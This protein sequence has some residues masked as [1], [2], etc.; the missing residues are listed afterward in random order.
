MAAPGVSENV[1]TFAFLAGPAAAYAPPVAAA[2]RTIPVIESRLR[3]ANDEMRAGRFGHALEEFDLALA[4][5]PRSGLARTGR[6][7]C[8]SQMGHGDAA[9]LEL[10]STLEGEEGAR[11]AL[12]L[13]RAAAK[14]GDIRLAVDLAC[15]AASASPRVARE[16]LD[17][18]RLAGVRDHPVFMTAL[19]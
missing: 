6:A 13:A 12:D 1:D 11:V 17:D 4:A 5:D 14:G 10:A 16:A 18:D 7:V 19:S 2:P 3:R 15:L 9:A 8:L